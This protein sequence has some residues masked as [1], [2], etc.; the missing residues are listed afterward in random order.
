MAELSPL[1]LQKGAKSWKF[2]PDFR[3]QLYSTHCDTETE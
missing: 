1:I 2:G 3:H